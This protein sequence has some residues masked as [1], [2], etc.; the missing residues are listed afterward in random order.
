MKSWEFSLI[1]DGIDA[2]DEGTIDAIV[3]VCDDEPL[4]GR[5]ED[6]HEVTFCREAPSLESAV[7]SAIVDLERL[8]GAQ[9]IGLR[10]ESFLSLVEIA[11][12]SGRSLLEAQRLIDLGHLT[13]P[14]PDPLSGAGDSEKV[15][16]GP[17][18]SAWFAKTMSEHLEDP[19]AEV[20]AKLCRQLTPEKSGQ[21]VLPRAATLGGYV[22][23]PL[24]RDREEVEDSSLV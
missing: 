20:F 16:Y 6:R 10:D 4:I 15:W 13:T 11:K 3:A 8:E 21:Q 23:A 1:V 7:S 5:T 14:F 17:E 22:I 9:V 2:E 24:E 12:L 18:V 19:N